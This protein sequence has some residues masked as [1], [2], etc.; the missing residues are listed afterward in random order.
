M[1]G[2]LVRI[3][4]AMHG[5]V[6]RNGATSMVWCERYM[7][8]ARSASGLEGRRVT[9][10]CVVVYRTCVCSL[11]EASESNCERRIAGRSGAGALA[12]VLWA[13][14]CVREPAARAVTRSR[15]VSFR[16]RR[17]TRDGKREPRRSFERRPLR[18]TRDPRA[19]RTAPPPA[20]RMPDAPCAEAH[21]RKRGD[22]S[23]KRD[24][25]ISWPVTD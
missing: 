4:R 19:E 24:D 16:I 7:R 22:E 1:C 18:W 20:A 25:A 10:W 15:A 5:R 2:C 8:C 17:S 13:T 9:R 6:T 23:R 21:A 11:S 3:R 14:I 12:C